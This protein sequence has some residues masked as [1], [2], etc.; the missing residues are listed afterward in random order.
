MPL[1]WKKRRQRESPQRLSD[2][3]MTPLIDLTFLLL[4][5]FIITFPLLENG[6]QVK[7]PVGKADPLPDKKPQH[8]TLDASGTIFLNGGRRPVSLDELEAGLRDAALKNP[9]LA[10]L[11][12]GDEKLE[13][14][15]VIGVMKVLYKL[16]ITRMALVTQAD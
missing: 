6:I 9:E 13:Y 15:K 2:V 7:L 8:V 10:V 4:I 1:R 5:T 12:R 16:K 14:A 3:N 11:I